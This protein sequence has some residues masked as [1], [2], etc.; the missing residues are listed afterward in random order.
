MTR[1]SVRW[2]GV[3]LVLVA[4]GAAGAAADDLPSVKGKRIAAKVG[5]EVITADELRQHVPDPGRDA[6]A[7]DRRAELT[8]LNRM[9]NVVLLA[10]EG[11]RMGL[12]KLPEVKRMLDSH[13]LISLREELV[14]R[15]VRNVEPDP[16][17]VETRYRAAVRQWIVSAVFFA[18]QAHASALA[19][20][21]AAGK[22]FG[23][24]AR[25]ALAAGRAT[26]HEDRVT[27]EREKTD[28]AVLKA[29]TDM[30]AGA[31]SP[32]IATQAGPAIVKIE[33]TRHPDDPATRASVEQTALG[34]K[35]KEV[36]TAFERE[37]RKKY[38]KVDTALLKSLDFESAT[39]GMDALLK[40][41][42]P[43]ATIKADRPITVAAMAEELK[44]QFFHGS[45]MA[46]ER[47][48][49][50]ARKDQVLDA[51]LHRRLFRK[52]ALRL[53]LDRT[54]SYRNKLKQY[55]SSLVF[56]LVVEKAIAPEVKVAD[57][58][59]RAYYDEHR[60]DF[61]TPEMMRIRSLVFADR[62]SAD[63]ALESLKKGADF[64]WVAG[65]AEGQLDRNAKGVLAF[66][67]MPVM[68]SEL[69]AD[70]RKAVAGSRGGD[71][72]MYVSPANHVYVLAVQ[73]VT[74]AAP[75]PFDQVRGA[76]AQRA[77]ERKLSAAIE[78]YANKL[79]ALSDVKVYLSAS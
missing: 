56:G 58:E 50:N 39:A 36:V 19:T 40:D 5:D 77:I 37:L 45:E 69:P 75:Q 48:R 47:G 10:Q 62:R 57:D 66:D 6:P 32:V 16:A 61:A 63:A 22:D 23:R 4:L 11:R 15:V 14:E 20:E 43:V 53:G 27:L 70:V 29:I 52:E 24:A 59:V 60:A 3:A 42:R 7:A 30:T 28:R 17:E 31:V 33:E 21:V 65:R 51:L 38:A 18:D 73:Q 55:A 35:R 41:T 79:R 71:A 34:Q 2:M 12:D 76:I 44:Y 13:A 25:E 72:R 8:V 78:A 1:G 64:Q 68:T 67:G 26:R 54:D 46:A 74:P 49:L 9:I